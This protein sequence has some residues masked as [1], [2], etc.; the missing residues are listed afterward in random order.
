MESGGNCKARGKSGEGGCYQFLDGTWAYWSRHVFGQVEPMTPINE[1]YVALHK[2][3][4]HLNQGHDEASIA[5]I[6]N[7]GNAG[8]CIRGVNRHQVAFDSCAYQKKVLAQL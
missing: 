1:E 5:R 4:L 6:W 7:Q 2:I 8:P 3:Q